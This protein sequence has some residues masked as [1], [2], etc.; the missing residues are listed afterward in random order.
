MKPAPLRLGWSVVAPL[1][2]A[3]GAVTACGVSPSDAE[4]AAAPM[5]VPP[6]QG[7]EGTMPPPAA[8]TPTPPSPAATACSPLVPRTTPLEVSVLPDAGATPFVSVLSRVG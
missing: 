7:G 1:L 6:D 2:I 3:L 4:P 5:A 8:T